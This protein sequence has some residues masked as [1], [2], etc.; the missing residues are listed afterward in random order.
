MKNFGFSA[1]IERLIYDLG[2]TQSS[3]SKEIGVSATRISNIIKNRNNPDSEILINILSKFR[4]VNPYWLLLGEGD[5]FKKEESLT[6]N[7]PQGTYNKSCS[8]CKE[9]D[10]L[11]K[12]LESHIEE[13][14]E[15]KNYYKKLLDNMETDKKQSTSA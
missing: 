5:V 4:N 10:K 12:T 9:K 15:D 14:T 7:E 1:R 13:I 2:Q 6:L 3:F 8:I 11:I